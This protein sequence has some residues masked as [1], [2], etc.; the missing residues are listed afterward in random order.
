[1]LEQNSNVMHFAVDNENPEGWIVKT[2]GQIWRQR[3]L[4]AALS[5]NSEPVPCDWLLTSKC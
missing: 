5:T 3:N 4:T 2:N 1:M